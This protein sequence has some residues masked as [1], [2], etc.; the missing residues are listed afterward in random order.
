[1]KLKKT[2]NIHVIW[3][4]FNV[5]FGVFDLFGACMAYVELLLS[6]S[7]RNNNSKPVWIPYVGEKTSTEGTFLGE[8]SL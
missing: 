6:S 8:L 2:W 5:L 3:I 4:T 1:M 7:T